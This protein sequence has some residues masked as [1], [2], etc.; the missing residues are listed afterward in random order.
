MY[1]AFFPPSFFSGSFHAGKSLE[2]RGNAAK[3]GGDSQR[4][5]IGAAKDGRGE[6]RRPFPTKQSRTQVAQ[7]R[8]QSKK[9][10]AF[11]EG[12]SGGDESQEGGRNN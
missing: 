4:A 8:L 7:T 6:T 5:R 2:N 9:D 12:S 10:G 11:V 1:L 3:S